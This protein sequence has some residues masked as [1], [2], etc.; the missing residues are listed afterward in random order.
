MN[1][2]FGFKWIIEVKAYDIKIHERLGTKESTEKKLGNL[3]LTM[4]NVF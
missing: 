3:F 1:Q 2:S 4:C